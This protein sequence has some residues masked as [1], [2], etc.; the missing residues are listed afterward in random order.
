MKKF[1]TS[2]YLFRG[3]NQRKTKAASEVVGTL[4]LIVIGIALFSLLALVTVT[5]PTIFFSN[6]TPAVNIVGTVE[7]GVVVFEHHGGMPVAL[8]SRITIMFA[9][10]PYV[11][12]VGNV[13]DAQSKADGAWTIGEKIIIPYTNPNLPIMQ[14][15]AVI[16]D[17]ASNSII[18]RGILQEGSQIV[19]PVATTLN[20]DS[21]TPNTAT[22]R[23]NYD[24]HY[25]LGLKRVCFT[26]IA[27]SEYEAN[28]SAAWSSTGWVTVSTQNG[29]YS[30]NL[31]GL[32]ENTQ[33]FYQAWVQYNSSL[34]MTQKINSS[35]T[36]N[37]FRTESYSVGM[38]HFNES[39]GLIVIDSS[40][41]GNNGTLYPANVTQTAQRLNQSNAVS[42]RS[43]RFD[44]YNDYVTINHAS[45][46]TPTNEIAIEAWVKPEY[47]TEFTGTNLQRL[48]S[49]IFGTQ[50]YACL[51]P[52]II[53]ISSD[54]YVIVS[55]N[56][57]YYGFVIT[58]QISSQGNITKNATTSVS[59]LYQFESSRCET[60]KIVKIVGSSVIYAIVYRGPSGFLTMV[61]VRIYTNGT[62]VKSV[63]AK[64]TLDALNCYYPDINYTDNDYYAIVYSSYEYYLA[65]NRY[66]GRLQIVKITSAGA[67]TAQ[68]SYYNFGGTGT[69]SGIMQYPDI[70][71][72]SGEYY[73]I[74]FRD[75][76]T[77][78]EIR[79][80][81]I[82]NGWI[83]FT[84]DTTY[85]FDVDNIS[86]MP[87]RI[88][89]VYDKTYAIL[90]GDKE[91]TLIRGAA[92]RT[93]IVSD[94]GELVDAVNYA[95]ILPP[96]DWA[97][98]T[99]PGII[100]I[101]GS[102]FAATYR[103]SNRAEVKT[104]EISK[105]GVIT[106]HT[107]D[108]A[109]KYVYQ[110]ASSYTI[111]SPKIIKV[112]S[113]QNTYAVVYPKTVSADTNNG[114]LLTLTIYKNGTIL[115]N[116]LDSVLLGPVN[117]Y[118]PDIIHVANDVYAVMS[119]KVLYGSM[120]LHT[121][122]ISSGGKIDHAFIDTLDIAMPETTP[123]YTIRIVNVA[124]NIYLIVFD[125]YGSNGVSLKTV[126]IADNGS[127]QDNVLCSY[128][129]T[130]SGY[131]NYCSPS[132]IRIKDTIFAVTYHLTNYGSKSDF[133]STIKVSAS[134][135]S[136]SPV[137]TLTMSAYFSSV[138][139]YDEYTKIIPINGSTQLYALL[140]GYDYFY[141][142]HRGLGVIF[143]LQINDTGHINQIPLTTFTFNSYG[144][145]RPD[146]V[147]LNKNI[148][149]MVYSNSVY[150][151]SYQIS[152]YIQT[153]N[154]STNGTKI[155]NVDS[156]SFTSSSTSYD[157]AH[158]QFL[159]PI[160]KDIYALIY[161]VPS[162]ST[163]RGY[164]GTI[165]IAPN[166][167]IYRTVSS[168]VFNA[169]LAF[170]SGAGILPSY[171]NISN[172]ALAI[173]YQGDYDDGYIEAIR[174]TITN[175]SSTLKNIISKSGSYSL[176]GNKTTFVATITTTS[177]DKTLSLP[178]HNG[179]NYLAVTYDHSKMKFFNNLTNVS[180]VCSANI[181]SSATQV[182]FG[183]FRG[184]YDE[185]AIYST[186]LRDDEII[187]HYTKNAP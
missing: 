101:N 164:I 36:I 57:N 39:S 60:P 107:N 178:L 13:L 14:I 159:D 169:Q 104:F 74:V 85:K 137:E 140:Y 43:L 3:K 115:K 1:G 170:V 134:N 24:F 66:V 49:T 117:F 23:M 79:N 153:I 62:I 128:N 15:S 95:K 154:I 90:F 99:D 149:A 26:Y 17:R 139:G 2:N 56:S 87:L 68:V 8:D 4:L 166:G 19:L 186:H 120:S 163:A 16:V 111:Y 133:L 102:I 103:I 184:I 92:V 61:T 25:Y 114:V 106:N 34:N 150:T 126:R 28:A 129:I 53:K 141:S 168:A 6:P 46:L 31:I 54:R 160:Y 41:H 143:T 10:T 152:G 151:S 183:G 67:I 121:I 162:G 30:Y 181:A 158:S 86:D 73:S 132:V 179:W 63:I 35:G 98:F 82:K 142:G 37:M 18:M 59:D 80:A 45:S 20:A 11:T 40:N 97:S 147:H 94:H 100:K 93:I 136:I 32:H 50:A 83:L 112:N 130:K 156:I 75:S 109:W 33:Y 9:E 51:E 7:N 135:G 187:D 27:V 167:S 89:Q 145:S 172:N 76:D 146:F 55:R 38:W 148:Y 52:D 185:F 155:K 29:S 78:G 42:N 175:T 70:I 144:C 44:G 122:R 174:V 58:A 116:T 88:I 113:T 138:S 96:A 5:L 77:D 119:R 125:N 48:N 12:T 118:A 123:G 108:A 64:V 71:N 22:V 124:N 173:C 110:P 180:L 81:Q 127:I 177:G 91:G 182:I 69:V 84:S 171:I 105:T 131:S 65:A 161:T 72:I 157:I 165:Q 47:K 176:K 21:I